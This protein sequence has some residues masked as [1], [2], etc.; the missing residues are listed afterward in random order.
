MEKKMKFAVI[1][2]GC[3]VYDGSEIHEAVFALLSIDR[4]G[5]EYQ[6]FAP[7]KDQ[8]HVINHLTGQPSNE[9]RNV[10]AESARIT[11]GK[12][13]PLSSF[14]SAD[15]DALVLP[16]GFGA[17][18]NLSTYAF[19][20]ENLKVDPEVEKA[21]IDMHKANKPIGAL[22]IAPVIVAKVIKG[23]KLTLGE[24]SSASKAAE[25]FGST[26]KIVNAGEIVV[27]NDNKIVSSPCYMYNARISEV[28]EGAENTIK[29]ILKLLK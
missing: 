26:H 13:K 5:G 19:D 15:F 28:A 29:A 27:D 23:A 24:I 12:I 14:N 1:L 18:K 20:G 25:K 4:N 11:R 8:Y 22:C 2:S 3:G 21:L 17:A 9:K 7:D 16:G 6:V 10:L